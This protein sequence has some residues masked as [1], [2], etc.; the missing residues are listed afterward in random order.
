MQIKEMGNHVALVESQFSSLEAIETTIE[1]PI[2]VAIR[3]APLSS[4]TELSPFVSFIN[5]VPISSTTWDYVSMLFSEEISRLSQS[6]IVDNSMN[7]ST[8][9]TLVTS[10][11]KLL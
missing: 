5:K 4:F 9:D 11:R 10:A 2:R 7:Q 8:N 6:S 1:E 3:P